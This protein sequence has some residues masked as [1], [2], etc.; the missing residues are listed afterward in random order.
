MG[1]FKSKAEKSLAEYKEKM[2]GYS[3]KDQKLYW[4]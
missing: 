1:L 3:H 2:I 4:H